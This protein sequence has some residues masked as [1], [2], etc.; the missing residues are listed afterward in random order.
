MGVSAL[1]LRVRPAGMKPADL[2]GDAFRGRSARPAGAAA[3][4]VPVGVF[5]GVLFSRWADGFGILTAFALVDLETG[6]TVY[7][8]TYADDRG[9][10]FEHGTDGPVLT[11]WAHLKELDCVPEAHDGACWS[12]IR[13]RNGIPATVPAPDCAAALARSPS[14]LERAPDRGLQLAVHVRVPRL[15][16]RD[17]EHLPDRPV[18]A[19][20][21]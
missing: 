15:S 6:K 21:P 14:A 4:N 13:A 7:E 5:E 1:E 9:I 20:A 17:A 19:V 2:C 11:Y 8:D 10:A 16:R 18:C 3:E 12:R